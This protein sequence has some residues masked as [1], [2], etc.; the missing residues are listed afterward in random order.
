MTRDAAHALKCLRNNPHA[1]VRLALSVK[2][3]FPPACRMM[4]AGMQMTFIDDFK[5]LRREYLYQFCLN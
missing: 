1:N 5:V 4:V 2:H 3:L